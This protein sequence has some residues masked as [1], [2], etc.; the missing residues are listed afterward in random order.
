M[1]KKHLQPHK[2][3]RAGKID[4]GKGKNR[5]DKL[6]ILRERRSKSRLSGSLNTVKAKKNWD[7]S[8][9]S[10]EKGRREFLRAKFEVTLSLSKY[11]WDINS[12]NKHILTH[13]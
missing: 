2:G 10:E 6:I 5:P 13:K 11:R 1:A 8:T 7:N 12:L 3:V 4:P 9:K